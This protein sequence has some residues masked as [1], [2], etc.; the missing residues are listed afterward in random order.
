MAGHLL[1]R[2]RFNSHNPSKQ[3]RHSQTRAP[4]SRVGGFVQLQNHNSYDVNADDRLTCEISLALAG[5]SVLTS[6]V[7][8][9]RPIGGKAML[10]NDSMIKVLD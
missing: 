8:P 6:I 2:L 7:E 9:D 5:T 4:K 10:K 1:S 3:K